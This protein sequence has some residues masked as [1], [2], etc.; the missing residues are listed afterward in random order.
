MGGFGAAIRYLAGSGKFVKPPPLEPNSST[1]ETRRQAYHTG[2]GR[3]YVRARVSIEEAEESPTNKPRIIVHE[4]PFQVNKARLLEKIADLVKEKKLEGISE[5]RDESDKDGMR[6]VIELKRGEMPDVA[7]RTSCSSLGSWPTFSVGT[8]C[9]SAL[10]TPRSV[11]TL[12]CN[13]G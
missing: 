1:M 5:L 8:T 10:H 9:E 11:N 3:V 2:R 6:M 7:L 12:D 13:I 4:L